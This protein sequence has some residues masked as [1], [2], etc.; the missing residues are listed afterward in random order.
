MTN[1]V[2]AMYKMTKNYH[3]LHKH[4]K[5]RAKIKQIKCTLTR[6]DLRR[7]F[8]N[9][10]H[11]EICNVDFVNISNHDAQPSVDRTDAQHGYELGNVAIICRK[12]NSTKAELDNLGY[13]KDKD[14]DYKKIIYEWTV[15][16]RH[17]QLISTDKVHK[18]LLIDARTGTNDV[19]SMRLYDS[20]GEVALYMMARRPSGRPGSISYHVWRVYRLEVGT[21]K[22]PILISNS[23]L[24]A[25]IK[26]IRDGSH[27]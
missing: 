26:H 4:I 2:V 18:Y 20:L 24:N 3:N 16:R 8:H 13:F 11:C 19:A 12:C 14:N 23:R 22:E 1:D 17:G 6:T 7:L 9:K 25:L 10:T 15:S 5:A 21:D 27:I